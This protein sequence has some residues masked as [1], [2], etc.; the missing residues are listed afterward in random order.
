MNIGDRVFYGCNKLASLTVSGNLETVSSGTFA[1]CWLLSKIM[2]TSKDQNF[3]VIDA[4]LFDREM[5][6][7]IVCF[8]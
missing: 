8:Q 1:F 2:A 6:R 3:N 7:L 5:N 4:V